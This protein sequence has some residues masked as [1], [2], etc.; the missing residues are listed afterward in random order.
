ME[1]RI[2]TKIDEFVKTFKDEI[3]EKALGIGF[4]DNQK[5]A[6]LMGFIYD[7]NRLSLDK[8]DFIKRKRVKNSIPELNRCIAKRANGEQC[9][10]RR[11]D[12]CEF[13]GTHSKGTPH[14][15]IQTQDV[16][17]SQVHQNMEVFAEEVKGIVYYLDHYQNVYKTEDIMENR[18][19]P[20]VI[21][22]WVKEGDTYT[23]PEL[24][25][26]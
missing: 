5:V 9:T 17:P 1:K 4:D 8:D 25:L 26:V 24:G 6:E 15:L 22:R 11:R 16:D 19:N 23:I 10:R 21:A 14:G 18:E 3:R 20:R 12:D 7:Y 2:N 13:C